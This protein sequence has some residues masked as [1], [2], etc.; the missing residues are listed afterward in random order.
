[1]NQ[2]PAEPQDD[3]YYDVDLGWIKNPSA[4][5]VARAVYPVCQRVLTVMESIG[6]KVVNIFGLNS[7]RF[8]YAVDEYERRERLKQEKIDLER[9]KERRRILEKGLQGIEADV[10]DDDDNIDI[11]YAPPLEVLKVPLREE[12]SK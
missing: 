9:E 5:R 12:D 3:S 10:A 8:Q 6:E 7:S 1:M 2:Q 11:P 4:R